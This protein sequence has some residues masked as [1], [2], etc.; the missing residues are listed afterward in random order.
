MTGN[1]YGRHTI[2]FTCQSF[3]PGTF[4][5]SQVVVDDFENV[6]QQSV[7]MFRGHRGAAAVSF[8]WVALWSMFP[9]VRHVAAQ[10]GQHHLEK[11]EKMHTA[12]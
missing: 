6:S 10:H 7:H 8:V 11:K 12:G 1:R 2:M 3:H 5:D 9:P 4:I